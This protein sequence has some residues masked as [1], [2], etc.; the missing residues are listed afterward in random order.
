MS[1]YIDLVIKDKKIRCSNCGHVVGIKK[2]D[3]VYSGKIEFNLIKTAKKAGFWYLWGHRESKIIYAVE[4]V[5]SLTDGLVLLKS[6]QKFNLSN[7]DYNRLV[8]FVEEYLQACREY[9]DA[10]ISKYAN[11]EPLRG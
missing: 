2:R 10:I 7:K 8:K 4:L 5:Q 3:F 11:R 9:P 1:L 6:N